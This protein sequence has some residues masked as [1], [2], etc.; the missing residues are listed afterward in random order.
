[1]IKVRYENEDAPLLRLGS[2]KTFRISSKKAEKM[3]DRRKIDLE[4]E[5]GEVYGAVSYPE[6]EP[7][8][9]P[10][11]DPGETVLESR[12]AIDNE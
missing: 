4:L 2:R 5:A 1:M 12:I 8:P 6:P 10:D 7:T 9:G 11:P 3:R